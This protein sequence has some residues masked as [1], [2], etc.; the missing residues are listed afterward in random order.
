MGPNFH[1]LMSAE[2]AKFPAMGISVLSHEVGGLLQV[3]LLGGGF[4]HR[5]GTHPE[6]QYRRLSKP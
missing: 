5:G 2:F 4:G 1:E 6:T 3:K